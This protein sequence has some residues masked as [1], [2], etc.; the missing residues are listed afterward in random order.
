MRAEADFSDQCFHIVKIIVTMHKQTTSIGRVGYYVSL[1]LIVALSLFN[2]NVLGASN[3]PQGK[4]LLQKLEMLDSMIKDGSTGKKIRAS[5]NQEARQLLK[6]AEELYALA[7]AS[8]DRG[9]LNGTHD[10]IDDAIRALSS[11]SS[12]ARILKGSSYSE[13]S[14]YQELLNVI[15]TLQENVDLTVENPV[16]LEK[17]KQMKSNADTLAKQDSYRKAIKVLDSAYQ[18]IAIAISENIQDT[19]VLYSLDFKDSKEEY[20]YEY[21]RYHGNLELVVTMLNQREESP[22]R[23]LIIRYTDLAESTL[24]RAEDLA[25]S[26]QHEEALKVVEQA[27]RDLSRAMGM[28]GLRF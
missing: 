7:R 19:T 2:Q 17:I 28:L 20:E 26:K 27:N 15:D 23:R 24:K 11:A 14:R 13:R 25:A 6:Q 12:E 16:D 21:R 1:S 18:I 4:V 8:I 22:T 3:D 10:I 5:D 9:D